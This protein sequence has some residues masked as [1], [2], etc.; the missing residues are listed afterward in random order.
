MS[1]TPENYLRSLA[2]VLLAQCAGK[3]SNRYVYAS[4]LIARSPSVALCYAAGDG[5]ERFGLKQD[6]LLGSSSTLIQADVPAT[7]KKGAIGMKHLLED[8]AFLAPSLVEADATDEEDALH[9]RKTA[10]EPP[11]RSKS[12]GAA[13]CPSA[14]TSR[15][16]DSP[17][18][19]PP[20]R[21][22]RPWMN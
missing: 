5:R 1:T 10:N 22:A 16:K 13:S 3:K 11:A 20:S 19:A 18:T 9:S 15:A 6:F 12:G 8:A 7:S 4:E 2:V 17:S 14:N 21:S